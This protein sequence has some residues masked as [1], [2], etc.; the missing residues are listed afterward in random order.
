MTSVACYYL[1]TPVAGTLTSESE[2]V[3]RYSCRRTLTQLVLSDRPG[4]PSATVLGEESP[5]RE[6][7][8]QG[9]A[10]RMSACAEMSATSET[11]SS[12][13]GAAA[14]RQTVDRTSRPSCVTSGRSGHV[15]S[16]VALA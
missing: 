11:G 2:G 12:S 6:A 15:S 16:P 9:M 3:Q 13:D 4:R 10:S 14:L 7:G 8:V 1:G 5:T